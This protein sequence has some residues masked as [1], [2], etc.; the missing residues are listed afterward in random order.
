MIIIDT[1]A[2]IF[3][4]LDPKKLTKKGLEAINQAEEEKHLYCCDITLWEVAML[5]SKKRLKIE[6]DLKSFLGLVL[7]ARQI[8]ILPIT[9]EIATL[10]VT[11]PSLIEH[12]DPADRLIAATTL[13]R[14]ASLVTADAKLQNMIDLP[15]I[16]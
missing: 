3:D 16:W 1:C 14:K 13:H 10:A 15:T 9:P 11:S 8:Q 4:S 6:I 2:L 5:V 7:E 12:G